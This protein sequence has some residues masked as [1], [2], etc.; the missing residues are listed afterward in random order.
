[1]QLCLLETILTQLS[2]IFYVDDVVFRTADVFHATRGKRQ[3]KNTQRHIILLGC[4]R[5]AKCRERKE[6]DLTKYD[7]PKAQPKTKRQKFQGQSRKN[8]QRQFL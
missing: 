3:G 2:V 1:M 5:K 7:F 6:F 4:D 8:K